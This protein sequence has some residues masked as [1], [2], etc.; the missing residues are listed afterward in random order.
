MTEH[1]ENESLENILEVFNAVNNK[2]LYKRPFGLMM[3]YVA[4]CVNNFLKYK[5]SID[6]FIFLNHIIKVHL[7]SPKKIEDALAEFIKSVSPAELTEYLKHFD[8]YPQ[9]ALNLIVK[10]SNMNDNNKFLVLLTNITHKTSTVDIVD[11]SKMINQLSGSVYDAHFFES[12]SDI[13]FKIIYSKDLD[14]HLKPF[15]QSII[16]YINTLPDEKLKGTKVINTLKWGKLLDVE[17]KS[18]NERVL[19]L[20]QDD[21]IYNIEDYIIL[22]E[23]CK[24]EEI[25]EFISKFLLTEVKSK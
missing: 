5:D 16:S 18:L 6:K 10:N 17:D 22:S 19:I 2:E 4:R 21:A 11:T 9:K 12:S 13:F 14:L 7:F 23:D 1:C 20:N 24:N 25:K 3:Q 15:M 8:S